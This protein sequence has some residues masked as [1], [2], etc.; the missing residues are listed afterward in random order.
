MQ[1]EGLL[2][3]ISGPSG[4]GKG[5]IC[6]NLV[7]K[8]KDI[9]VSVSATTRPPRRGE[10]DGKNYYFLKKEEFTRKIQNEEFLEWAEVYGNFYGTLKKPVTEKLKQGKDIILEIDIQGAVQVK[11]KFP[12]GVFVFILPP[13]I[14]ELKKRIRSRGTETKKEMVKRISAAY[15]EI[16]KAS[17]YD[18]VIVNDDVEKATYKLKAIITA[19]K[20]KLKRNKHLIDIGG[21]F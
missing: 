13:S 2:I 19:E 5:T 21:G 9:E 20:C 16:K 18:Y 14:Q 12:N 8:N 1:N 11:Q 7:R 4:A 15:D 6:S 10:K 17:Q 3:V